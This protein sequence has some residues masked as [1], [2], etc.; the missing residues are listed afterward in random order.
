[1]TNNATVTFNSSF[2]SSDV[3]VST[4][5]SVFAIVMVSF[6]IV[7]LILIIAGNVLVLV[8]IHKIRALRDIT[9][10]FVGNLALADLIIGITLP[11]QVL[12]FFYPDLAKNKYV[13]MSRFLIVSF[14]CNASI[15]SLTCTVVDRYVAIVYPLRYPDIMTKTSAF[16]M[17][18]AIWILDIALTIVPFLG[19]NQWGSSPF[20]IY[21]LVI[22]WEYR[23][24]LNFVDFT[25]AI[26]MMVLYTHILIIAHKKA[27]K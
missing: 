23:L 21:P 18:A 20:C 25:C 15:F 3:A 2:S 24:T 5:I 10:I 4:R 26:F 8:A 6:Q 16:V 22:S 27:D 17:V 7:L 19:V 1:M 9:G 13:C 12:F 14:S 11:F